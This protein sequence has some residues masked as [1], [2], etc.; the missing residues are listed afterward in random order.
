MAHRGCVRIIGEASVREQLAEDQGGEGLEERYASLTRRLATKQ[1]E[2]GRYIKLYAQGHLDEGERDVHLAD[3][4]D[5]VEN[6]KLL[7]SSI[8]ADLATKHENKMVAE[9]AEV[10]LKTLR[11]SLSEVEQN[12]EEAWI[13]RR[14][15]AKLLVERIVIGRDEE[16]R[17][18][19]DFTYRFGL[20]V[21][22]ESADGVQ[23]SQ[24][25]SRGCTARVAEKGLLRGHPQVRVY[26]IA[27]ER[28]AE[29][30]YGPD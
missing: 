3:L 5:Q 17:T 2:K 24:R 30:Y 16:G 25:S 29:R 8:E 12:S 20:P 28:E 21:V 4:K 7:I 23:I 18:K 1:E 15:L 6:L 19:M 13:A 9:S 14:E 22:A 11:K 10:W 26:E 27:V